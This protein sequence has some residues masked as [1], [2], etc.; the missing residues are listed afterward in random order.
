MSQQKQLLKG[1]SLNL[2]ETD[3]ISILEDIYGL[4]IDGNERKHCGT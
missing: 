2:T 3:F 4:R 1:R